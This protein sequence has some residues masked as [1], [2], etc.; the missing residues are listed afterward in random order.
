MRYEKNDHAHPKRGRFCIV[1]YT[2]TRL[3]CKVSMNHRVE[4]VST[5]N[6]FRIRYK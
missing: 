6:K 5:Y 2:D 3:R 4:T 1:K